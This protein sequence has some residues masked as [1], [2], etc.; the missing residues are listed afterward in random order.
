MLTPTFIYTFFLPP[1]L[2]LP[3]KTEYPT[4]DPFS[5]LA[6]ESVSRLREK[7]K[8]NRKL[9]LQPET[10][11]TLIKGGAISWRPNEGYCSFLHSV[12]AV[13]ERN[14]LCMRPIEY[15]LK[16]LRDTVPTEGL[17]M[18]FG[19]FTVNTRKKQQLK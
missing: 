12:R 3:N 2:P 5:C 13:L 9:K 16:N 11:H 8:L 6:P 18:E 1:L 17:M 10:C 7:T 4:T 19:V 14:V 15:V